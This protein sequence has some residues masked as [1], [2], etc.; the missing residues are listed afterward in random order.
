M[1]IFL[2]YSLG[3]LSDMLNTNLPEQAQHLFSQQ[4][5]NISSSINSN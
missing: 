1:C 4:A 5:T 2:A 3:Y